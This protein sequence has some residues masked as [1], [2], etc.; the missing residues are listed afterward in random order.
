MEL[1]TGQFSTC[2]LIG[3]SRSS[4]FICVMFLCGRIGFLHGAHVEGLD[5]YM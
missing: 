3:G 5:F 2:D 1:A 4:Y